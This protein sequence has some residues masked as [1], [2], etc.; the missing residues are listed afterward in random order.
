MTTK[1]KWKINKQLNKKFHEKSENILA[2]IET[3]PGTDAFLTWKPTLMSCELMFSRTK[4][5]L[6]T[7]DPLKDRKRDGLQTSFK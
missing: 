6:V 2:I 1:K 7:N 4:H 3:V 5:R